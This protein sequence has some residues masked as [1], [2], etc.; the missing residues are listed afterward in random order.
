MGTKQCAGQSPAPAPGPRGHLAGENLGA[1][2]FRFKG[3]GRGEIEKNFSLPI[4]ELAVLDGPIGILP[5][6]REAESNEP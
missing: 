5:V 3:F 2:F 4:K 1:A 6:G